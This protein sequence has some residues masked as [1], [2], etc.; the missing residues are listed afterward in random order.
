[1]PTIYAY[2]KTKENPH[3][4]AYTIAF[5]PAGA[6]ALVDFLAGHGLTISDTRLK[7]NK[8]GELTARVSAGA[9]IWHQIFT[10][11]TANKFWEQDH[12]IAV[13]RTRREALARETN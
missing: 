2:R 3:T 4:G 5:T 11:D 10:P 13:M 12:D 7:M 8:S 9:S 6:S 1:M